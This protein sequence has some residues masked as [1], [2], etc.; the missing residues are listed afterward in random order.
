MGK[1]ATDAAVARLYSLPG[2]VH[3]HLDMIIPRIFHLMELNKKALAEG[4]VKMSQLVD[5]A[6]ARLKDG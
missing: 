1:E 5:I 4:K 6:K 3:Q 2:G